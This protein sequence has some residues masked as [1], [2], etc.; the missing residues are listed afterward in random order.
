[1]ASIVSYDFWGNAFA[2]VFLSDGSAYQAPVAPN[3]QPSIQVAPPGTFPQNPDF[4][5]AMVSTGVANQIM[6]AIIAGAGTLTQDGYFIWDG[7]NLYQAGTASPVA[8]ILDGGSGFGSAPQVIAYG[9][10]GTGVVL[11]ST[12]SGDSVALVNVLN[13]G[14][15]FLPSDPT[16]I[17]L[18]FNGN[19]ALNEPRTAYGRG[20]TQDGVLTNVTVITGGLGFTSI[21]NLVF[22]PISGGSGASG[23]VSSISGGVITGVQ[24]LNGGSGYNDGVVITTSGGGGSG[25]EF[26]GV[27]QDGVITSVEMINVGNGYASVPT[28]T[29]LTNTGSGASGTALVNNGAVTFVQFDYPSQGGSGYGSGPDAPIVQFVGGDGPA[30]GTLTLMPFGV[31]GNA[32]EMYQ[33]RVWIA[34][35]RRIL[36]TAPGSIVDFGDGGGVF[37]STDANL[38]SF[39]TELKQSNGFLYLFADSSVWYLSGV[40]TSGS[41]PLTTFSL[42]NVDPQTGTP[43]R[44]SVVAFGRT[45]IFANATGIFKLV[46]GAVEKISEPLDPLFES[47]SPLGV[48]LPNYLFLPG[49]LV[50]TVSG[51]QPSSALGTVAGKTVYMLSI[52]ITNPFSGASPDFILLM[53]DG[54]RWWTADQDAEV[55][56]VKTFEQMSF[57]FAIGSDTQRLFELFRVPSE[58]TTKIIQSKL[59]I[60]PSIALQKKSWGMYAMFAGDSAPAVLDFTVD[61][62][63]GPK[64]VTQGTFAATVGQTV[65]ARSSAPAPSGF[66]IGFTMQTNSGDFWVVDLLLIGQDYAL[67]T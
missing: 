5:P 40:N 9:G 42:L 21:P 10:S 38:I 17:L 30:S 33:G 20:I 36:F 29:Y 28:V 46:G 65:M 14:S 54:K 18:V 45:L 41:P 34:N 11:S 22:T 26:L 63:T 44:E 64:T 61:S 35:L 19:P 50:P 15:G 39:Y 3:L 62:E 49:R 52:A 23:V 66:S 2:L 58:F 57:F 59:H 56:Y 13:P 43:W 53:W 48:N 24:V 4:P 25:A 60:E 27:V 47:N 1:M 6:V 16:N 32:I 7:T 8:N 31:S 55:R 12:L 51:F 37:E 67:D